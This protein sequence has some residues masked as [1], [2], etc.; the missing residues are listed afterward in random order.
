MFSNNHH[1]IYQ[2]LE[3]RNNHDE[4]IKH[5]PYE[6]LNKNAW[7]GKGYYFWDRNIDLAHAWGRNSYQG[8]YIICRAHFDDSKVFDLVG[9]YQH[10]D[11]LKN[12]IE[13][14]EEQG[15]NC[16]VSI[17]IGYLRTQTDFNQKFSVIKAKDEKRPEEENQLQFVFGKTP[18]MNLAP[19]IQYCFFSS[20]SI[21]DYHIIFPDEYIYSEIYDIKEDE[22]LYG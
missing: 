21:L 22:N 20:S 17:A 13:L 11:I 16:T 9:N 5:G 2:T 4:I 10:I 12:V 15:K 7:L 8:N 14:V 3:D 19:R 1:I 6:C 18:Y